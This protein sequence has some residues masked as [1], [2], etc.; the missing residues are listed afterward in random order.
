MNTIAQPIAKPIDDFAEKNRIAQLEAI[1]PTDPKPEV[2]APID[3]SSLPQEVRDSLI[4]VD[5]MEVDHLLLTILSAPGAFYTVDRIILDAWLKHEKKI[6]RPKI[7][8]RLR[9]LVH[10]GFVHKQA[11]ARGIFTLTSLGRETIGLNN[12]VTQPVQA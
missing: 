11:R 5:N 7:Q 1:K 2:I 6:L 4:G 8:Q 10:Q 9:A 3:V 12:P